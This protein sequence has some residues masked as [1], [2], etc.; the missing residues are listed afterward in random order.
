MAAISV[1][2]FSGIIRANYQSIETTFLYDTA[3]FALYTSVSLGHTKKFKNAITSQAGQFVLMLIL[4]PLFLTLVPINNFFVQLVALRGNAWLL[5]IVIIATRIK[6]DDLFVFAR[7]F[8]ILNVIAM[9]VG[10][11]LYVKGVESL[12]PRNEV[13]RVIYSSKDVGGTSDKEALYRIPSVFLSAHAYGGTMVLTIPF[14]LGGLLYRKRHIFERALFVAGLVGA[15]A[16]ILFCAARQPLWMLGLILIA[17]WIQTGMSPKVGIVLGIF[18]ACGLYAISGNERFQR[19]IDIAKGAGDSSFTARRIYGS[20]NEEL[21]ETFFAYPMG[22]GM[23][24]SV[25]T[26]IPY[27]LSDFQPKAIGAENEYSRIAVDQGWIG[28]GCWIFFLVWTHVPRPNSREPSLSF[29]LRMMHSTTAMM[30]LTAFIGTGTLSSV[31]SSTIAL[32]M[33]GILVSQREEAFKLNRLQKKLRKERKIRR[34]LRNP[35]I[36]VPDSNA[37][38]INPPTRALNPSEVQP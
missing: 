13:T 12:Y 16:G 35:S 21:F 1:G 32:T 37:S 2:Y 7:G 8:A 31:P 24:S 19:G 36:P 14:L 27:F 17:T 15:V 9:A 30:W 23:G 38:A 28:L 10:M 26:S 18:A 5:P 34:P 3:I 22:A 33:M 6:R 4:W 25:G 11:Y 20:V 29:L